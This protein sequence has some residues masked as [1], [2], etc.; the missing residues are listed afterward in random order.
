MKRFFPRMGGRRIAAWLC[1]LGLGTIFSGESRADWKTD[2][3]KAVAAAKKEGRFNFY[4]GRYG[5]EPLLNEFRRD[6]PEIKIISVN[7]TGNSLGTRILTE[8]RAGKVVA[9]LYSGGANTNYEILYKGK[10]LESIKSA[11]ILPEVIDESKWYGGQ[12]RYTDPEQKFI[13]VYIATPSSSGFY[14]NTKLVNPQEFKSY[15]D[16]VNSKWKGRYVSQ[17]P[18]ST[19][20]GGGLQFY[21][22]N[23]ELGPEFIKRLFGD[24][25][26][27]FGRDRRQITD[28]LA[29]GRFALCV[30][31]RETNR[32]KG[33]GLPVD[34]L[35]STD[36][37]EGIELTSGGGSISLVK[38]GP[39]PNAA[40]VFI[41]WFLSRKGQTA[42]QKYADLYG[43]EPPNSRRI[44]IPKDM[45]PPSSRLVP[46]KKYFDVSDP[47]YA[48][49]E[50][51]FKLV[52][53]LVK[54]REQKKE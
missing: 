4:V 16:L 9:D 44:D 43:E 52:K 5:T 12:Q 34:E 20:L 14:Y 23:P 51:I 26:P 35:E 47:K 24:M 25:Q 31:C 36:W 18:T 42:L 11:L 49:M 54:G 6:Y 37:K 13:F 45:L 1:I 7:G 33:Q 10:A 21:Y 39:N 27:V 3:E 40:K 48:D 30:G 32:A 53:E 17:E 41:N 46:G 28:W 50:P 19:G 2:W 8:I 29:Q 15:W 22:Y 38:G